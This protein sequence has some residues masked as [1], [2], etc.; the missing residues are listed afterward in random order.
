MFANLVMGTAVSLDGDTMPRPV[1]H[2]AN[3]DLNLLVALRELLRERSVTR[4]AERFGVTRPAASADFDPVTSEREFT[5]VMADYT[6]VVMGEALSQVLARAVPRTRLHIRL[7]RESLSAEYA[8]GIRFIDGMVAPPTHGFALPDTRS[9][10]LFRDRWVCLVDARNPALDAGRLRLADLARLR[11]SRCGWR[12]TWPCRTSWPGPTGSRSCRSDWPR[13]SPTGWT[14]GCSSAPASP[15]P[16]RRIPELKAGLAGQD[17]AD[18]GD[19]DHDRRKRAHR[20][21]D[22]RAITQ[23]RHLVPLDAPV[24]RR[25]RYAP[26]LWSAADAALKRPGGPGRYKPRLCRADNSFVCQPDQENL[27]YRA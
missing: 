23:P 5:L 17:G 1:A 14:C 7:V 27:T 2:L 15:A 16:G 21:Q 20:E 8:D 6:I 9:A 11:G 13:G 22:H 12:A 4:V 26:R 3:L 18:H 19:A 24:G 25:V 10:E